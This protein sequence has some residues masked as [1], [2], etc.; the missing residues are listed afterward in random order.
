M[1]ACLN[2]SPVH[3]SFL[4]PLL[5]FSI[6]APKPLPQFISVSKFTINL[7]RIMNYFVTIKATETGKHH[8][9]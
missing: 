1:S 5:P 4:S 8:E 6:N 7:M 3:F 2:A 9:V